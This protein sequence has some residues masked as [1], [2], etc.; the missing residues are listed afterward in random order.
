[1]TQTQQS[2]GQQTGQQ[3]G[4]QSDQ[5]NQ[6]SQQYD[7][8]SQYSGMPQSGF[9]TTFLAQV[10]QGDISSHSVDWQRE[11]FDSVEW[12]IRSAP[13]SRGVRCTGRDPADDDR[14]DRPARPQ[15]GR[16]RP[17]TRPVVPA[18]A[19]AEQR[20][21]QMTGIPCGPPRISGAQGTEGLSP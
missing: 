4:Q 10:G 9:D 13:T 5:Q 7:Q 20:Q 2:T 17:S 3:S 12:Q 16:R 6:S 1:M 14:Q 8:S 11:Y 15:P 19:P 18:A 21:R